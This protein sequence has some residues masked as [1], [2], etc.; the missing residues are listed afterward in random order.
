MHVADYAL[1]SN[2][3]FTAAD[4]L[5]QV[6]H[7]K[8]NGVSGAKQLGYCLQRCRMLNRALFSG[9]LW[10]K[11]RDTN[12]KVMPCLR[13][14][15]LCHLLATSEKKTKNRTVMLGWFLKL[16]I[17]ATHK[18]PQKHSERSQTLCG[19]VI[20]CRLPNKPTK[21]RI[22]NKSASA[23]CRTCTLANKIRHQIN[24]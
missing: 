9:A 16:Y 6:S 5:L 3:C 23:E 21:R 13:A 7:K 20:N 15:A 10:N 17:S 8:N 4:E 24:S 14:T 2:S 22:W 11:S 19:S 18:K 1:N 12:T